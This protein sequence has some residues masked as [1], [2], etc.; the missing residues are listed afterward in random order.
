MTIDEMVAQILWSEAERGE[1]VLCND[2]PRAMPVVIDG[3]MLRQLANTLST[4]MDISRTRGRM[5]T[6]YRALQVML[7]NA[8]PTFSSDTLVEAVAVLI[9]ERD[10]ARSRAQSVETLAREYLD[11][12][13]VV[14]SYPGPIRIP[15]PMITRLDNA[16]DALRAAVSYTTTK[17]ATE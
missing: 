16:V 5:L 10:A 15:D 4:T 12:Q 11:A 2:N 1:I 3:Q 9:A 13:N 6:D 14:D 8:M 7:M 17:G